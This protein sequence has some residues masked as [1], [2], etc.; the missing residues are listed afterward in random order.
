[1]TRR[2][3]FGVVAAGVGGLRGVRTG[4]E[5]DRGKKGKGGRRR[6]C[7]SERGGRRRGFEGGRSR[8]ADGGRRGPEAE[9]C[10]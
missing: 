5:I 9:A 7:T 4:C 6:C 2:T 3:S 1:M 10:W 8:E